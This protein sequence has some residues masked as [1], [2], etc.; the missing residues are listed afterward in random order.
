[1]E[2]GRFLFVT[3]EG[4]GNLT[5]L[6]G[7]GTQLT[8][9]GHAVDVLGRASLRDRMTRA[10]LGF[11][12]QRS[13]GWIPDATDVLGAVEASPPDALVV[14]FMVPRAL[15]AAERLALPTAA[16]VH[17]L[18]AP[19]ADN[20]FPAIE[21]DAG[22]DEVNGLRTELGL[23]AVGRVVDLLD[24]VHVILAVTTPGFDGPAAV[25]HPHTRYVGPVLEDARGTNWAPPMPLED[26]RPLVVVSMGTTPMDEQ[27][28]LQR[29]LDAL[30]G[31]P[32]RV[33]VQVGTHLSADAFAVPANAAVTGYVPH[34]A[35]LPHA[36][37]VVTHAGLGTVS[38][39]L[40]CG[41]PLVCLPLGRDQPLNAA[42]VDAVGAGRVVPPDAPADTITAAVTDVLDTA[43]YRDAAQ[44]QAADVA[45][46]HDE[47]LAVAAVEELLAG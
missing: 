6:L 37:L 40:A 30:G 3:W 38:A 42:R 22:V 27:P 14:D 25:V 2:P 33:L 1:M 43:R 16:L 15:C 19:V 31:L 46:A 26:S 35:V 23:A 12:P 20:S 44:R 10:G 24:N 17:T 39:A 32:V 8:A 36:A 47:G 45:R 9:R 18:Y 13:D 21:M 41:V 34:A 11:V 5:P 4:G 28:V 7:L 29:V